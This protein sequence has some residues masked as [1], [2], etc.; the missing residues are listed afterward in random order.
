MILLLPEVN[1]ELT[2]PPLSQSTVTDP[3]R[4][5][6]ARK[7]LLSLLSVTAPSLILEAVTA[8]DL[9]LDAV[10]AF[11]AKSPVDTHFLHFT[12][13]AVTANTDDDIVINMKITAHSA[14][15]RCNISMMCYSNQFLY[16]VLDIGYQK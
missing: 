5:N 14:T 12:S 3:P 2:E 9:I 1:A 6:E 15:V 16:L 8:R 11:F 10:T 13:S 4:P 7:A